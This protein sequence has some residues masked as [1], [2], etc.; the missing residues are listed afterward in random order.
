MLCENKVEQPSQS[1][2]S[3]ASAS[4]GWT[5]YTHSFLV[6]MWLM[7]RSESGPL[8]L[9]GIHYKCCTCFFLPIVVSVQQEWFGYIS[10]TGWKWASACLIK[11]IMLQQIL[12]P[13]KQLRE[14]WNLS[15]KSKSFRLSISICWLRTN[16]T[17]IGESLGP[18]FLAL[19]VYS[20]MPAKVSSS[21]CFF[22]F[23]FVLY[24]SNANEFF[25]A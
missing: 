2:A 5:C 7:C 4:L 24:F 18:L 19:G 20:F 22:L 11:S 13:Q 1:G 17:C 12:S 9:F 14:A 15:G 21:C 8:F 10:T 3:L 23:Y 25:S 6:L 16:F